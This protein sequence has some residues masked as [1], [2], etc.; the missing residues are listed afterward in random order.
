MPAL[1]SPGP[2]VPASEASASFPTIRLHAVSPGRERQAGEAPTDFS[3][4]VRRHH[5][6]I[7]QL[8]HGLLRDD[9]VAEKLTQ[10]VFV[11]AHRRFAGGDTA[12]AVTLWIYHACLRF[13]RR[14]HW[15]SCNGPKRRR[16]TETQRGRH[17]FHLAAF[18]HM[19]ATRSQR[20]NPHDCELLALRHV[21]GLSLVQIGQLRRMSPNEVADR[22][23]WSRASLHKTTPQEGDAR[24]RHTLLSA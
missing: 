10:Q 21:L 3:T 18:V 13:A 15:K 2:S 16:L 22:L 20:I 8:L 19:L 12:Q 6:L 23:A 1:D 9:V 7:F 17:E 24:I 4:L 11:R 5:R 14:Y